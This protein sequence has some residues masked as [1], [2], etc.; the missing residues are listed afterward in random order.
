M[1]FSGDRLPPQ[2]ARGLMWLTLARDGNELDAG[3]LQAEQEV[4]FAAEPIELRDHQRCA[5]DLAG[6]QSFVKR[7]PVV[8]VFSALDFDQLLDQLP[9]AAVQKVGDRLPLRFQSE[10]A[11]ALALGRD[12]EIGNELAVMAGH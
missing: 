9:I 1:L 8:V 12:A 6:F 4:R 10:S 3:L 11:L 5:V 2:R 7:R